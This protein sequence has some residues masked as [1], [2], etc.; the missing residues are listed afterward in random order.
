MGSG[1]RGGQKTAIARSAR[2]AAMVVSV[3]WVS[4]AA[5][6]DEEKIDFSE[7]GKFSVGVTGGT[8]G[9]GAEVAAKLHPNFVVRGTG[10][11]WSLTT[12]V[13]LGN[14]NSFA[15]P[16]I[17]YSISSQHYEYTSS[18]RSGGLLLDVHAFRDGG[19]M[20][21]GMRYLSFDLDGT[22]VNK[23]NPGWV[24]VGSTVYRTTASEAGNVTSK[25]TN[26]STF[27]PYFGLGYDSS[28]FKHYGLSLSLDAGVIFGGEPK[29]TVSATGTGVTKTDLDAEQKKIESDFKWLNYYPVL[30]MAAKYRF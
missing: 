17:A 20:T 6:A 14:D 2:A 8:L 21:A 4:T 11:A 19:R 13:V 7:L 9:V 27:L 24:K 29:A 16:S 30:M 23:N 15:V 3:G 1:K 22:L 5:L 18:V 26:S 12:P 10:S 28:F 25:V